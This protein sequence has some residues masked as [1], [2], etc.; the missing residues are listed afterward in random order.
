MRGRA[1]FR[2]AATAFLVL[3]AS[4][5]MAT[6]LAIKPE[7]VS[8]KALTIWTAFVEDKD[9]VVIVRGNVKRPQSKVGIIA[10]HLHIVAHRSG[11]LA[12]VTA[13]TRWAPTSRLMAYSARLPIADAATITSITVSYVPTGDVVDANSGSD[14]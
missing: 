10:G 4:A 8:G 12:D 2:A 9:D 11:G 1:L 7:I 5:A 14:T 13:D 6:R 3:T